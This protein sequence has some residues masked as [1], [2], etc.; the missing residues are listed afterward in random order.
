MNTQQVNITLANPNS[1][2]SFLNVAQDPTSLQLPLQRCAGDCD[3][4]THC[5]SGLFCQ[6]NTGL[7][8]VPGCNGTQNTWDYCVDL[9]DFDYGFTLLPTGGWTDDWQMSKPLQVNFNGTLHADVM[10][11]IT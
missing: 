8:R 9:D 1:L 5:M 2:G 11:H 6:Q 4:N 7:E 10:N 3:I